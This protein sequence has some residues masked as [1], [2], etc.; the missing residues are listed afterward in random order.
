MIQNS[1][2]NC[3]NKATLVTYYTYDT[4]PFNLA[5]PAFRLTVR[6]KIFDAQD[7]SIASYKQRIRSRD[8]LSTSHKPFKLSGRQFR[9]CVQYRTR[10]T[11]SQYC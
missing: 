8:N 6:S 3:R 7:V 11:A 9:T 10:S 5:K 2:L 1:T 4:Y